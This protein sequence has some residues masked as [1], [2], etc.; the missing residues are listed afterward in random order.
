MLELILQLITCW[1]EQ[2]KKDLRIIDELYRLA[3]LTMEDFMTIL[4]KVK[5]GLEIES[6]IV[7]L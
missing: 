1:R 2:Q 7:K 3:K 4:G 5:T 6:Y